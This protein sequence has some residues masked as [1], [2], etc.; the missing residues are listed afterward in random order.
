MAENLEAWDNRC[1]AKPAGTE[2][3]TI[4]YGEDEKFCGGPDYNSDSR[5]QEVLAK[6]NPLELMK[7]AQESVVRIDPT[8]EGSWW[9]KLT[10]EDP[11][12]PVASGSGFMVG[13]TDSQCLIATNNHLAEKGDLFQVRTADGASYPAKLEIY[14]YDSDLA[15]LSVDK[16]DLPKNGSAAIQC[17]PLSLKTVDLPDQVIPESTNAI[18]SALKNADDWYREKLSAPRP[19]TKLQTEHRQNSAERDEK[20]AN[21]VAL[22]NQDIVVASYPYGSNKIFFSPGETKGIVTLADVGNHDSDTNNRDS[23]VIELKAN[24]PPGGFGGPVFDTDGNVIA[25]SFAAF[26]AYTDR[27]GGIDRV[28]AVPA[29]DVID[30][31]EKQKNSHY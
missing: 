4:Y 31:L 1:T 5:A 30:L 29:Q 7:T 26:P 12:S 27:E 28:Y 20:V 22:N 3:P 16:M 8:S 23:E 15:I 24:V 9:D 13:E 18:V 10:K 14:D 11:T 25:V 2:I 17:H 21:G 6:F 19:E